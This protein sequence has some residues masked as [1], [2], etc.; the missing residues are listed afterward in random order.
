MNNAGAQY[1]VRWCILKRAV[2]T[3]SA[4]SDE[5]CARKGLCTSEYHVQLLNKIN[6]LLHA[7]KPVSLC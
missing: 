3:G 2:R 1:D 7:G 4:Q 6:T 5:V